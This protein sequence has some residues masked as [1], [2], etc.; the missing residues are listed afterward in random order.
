MAVK[1][2]GDKIQLHFI[3]SSA[4]AKPATSN[5]SEH[6]LI[7]LQQCS[8]IIRP[9]QHKTWTGK[10]ITPLRDRLVTPIKR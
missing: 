9:S 2:S 1:D 3:S 8:D 5:G 4:P 10:L 7:N 6:L